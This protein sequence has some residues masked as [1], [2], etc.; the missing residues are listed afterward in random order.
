MNSEKTNQTALARTQRQTKKAVDPA[1]RPEELRELIRRHEHAYY[2]LDEPA[3]SDAQYDSLFL[4]LRRIT[5]ERPDLLTTDYPSY[6]V[7]GEAS[8]Q[9][10]KLRHPS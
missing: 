8:D 5:D 3:V 7:A 2:V 9:F 10:A 6:R 1:V 4:D